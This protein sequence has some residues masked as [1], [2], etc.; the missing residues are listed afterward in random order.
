M[1][2]HDWAK[3]MAELAMNAYKASQPCDI[4]FG[5]VTSQ[6]PLSV[7]VEMLKLSLGE[8]YLV[9]PDYLT[10]RT[11][12]VEVDGKTGTGLIPGALKVGDR[13]I[14]MMKTGGQKYV[15]IGKET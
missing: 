5:T 4:C 6:S 9:V 13:V 2:K 8:K 14:L 3:G 15:I 1:P 11:I 12:K 10:D 7:D